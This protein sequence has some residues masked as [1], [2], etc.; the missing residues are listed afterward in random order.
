MKIILETDRLILREMTEEDDFF[1]Y[2]LLNSDGWLEFI[3]DRNIKTVEDARNH[4]LNNYIKMYETHGFGLWVVVRKSD[5][6]CIG[7]CGLI[8]RPS[9]ADVDIGFAFLSEYMGE[10]Y[11][12]EAATASMNYGYEVMDMNRIVAITIPENKRSIHLL[13]KLVIQFALTVYGL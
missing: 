2:D 1:M 10:G 11:A 7:T 6:T 3:G 12:Y 9:L 4:I 5:S 13:Q 8:K